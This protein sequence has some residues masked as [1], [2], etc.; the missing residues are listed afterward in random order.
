MGNP[1]A[2]R[3]G[4]PRFTKA[5][6]PHRDAIPFP[7]L[8]APTAGAPFPAVKPQLGAA[9]SLGSARWPAPRAVLTPIS[10]VL[11]PISF[12]S[13]GS[14]STASKQPAPS[15]TAA[16]TRPP[17]G[18]IADPQ[19]AGGGKAPRRERQTDAAPIGPARRLGTRREGQGPPRPAPSA[20]EGDWPAHGSRPLRSH[21]PHAGIEVRQQRRHRGGPGSPHSR[22]HGPLPLHRRARQRPPLPPRASAVRAG[23]GWKDWTGGGRG[24]GLG[25]CAPAGERGFPGHR[26]RGGSLHPPQSAV[27]TRR[28]LRQLRSGGDGDS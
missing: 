26:G 1:T 28:E 5:A 13:F 3:A 9:A 25:A 20:E 10:D 7:A 4:R 23:A 2:L 8:N 21:G 15:P 14:P 24:A 19:P 18:V 27:K 16:R 6:P 12:P 17:C 22:D 11:T